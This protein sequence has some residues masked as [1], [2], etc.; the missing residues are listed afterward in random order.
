MNGLLNKDYFVD[1]TNDIYN[2]NSSGYTQRRINK[3]NNYIP[4]EIRNKVITSNKIESNKNLIYK[5]IFPKNE[6]IIRKNN[7]INNN[8]IKSNYYNNINENTNIN[9]N[10]KNPNVIQQRK[11][12]KLINIVD[13]EKENNSL[14][15]DFYNNNDYSSNINYLNNYINKS[16]KYPL[17][18]SNNKK[19]TKYKINTLNTA[20]TENGRNINIDILSDLKGGKYLKTQKSEDNLNIILD[21]NDFMKSI[22]EINDLNILDEI[23]KK[24]GQYF[25]TAERINNMN[26]GKPYISSN[27][28]YEKE[29]NVIKRMPLTSKVNNN[30]N[31]RENKFENYKK[32]NNK[33]DYFINKISKK[34]SNNQEKFN[35]LKN[36]TNENRIFNNKTY[37]NRLIINDDSFY[38]NTENL[39]QQNNPILATITH[40][41]KEESKS[42][43]KNYSLEEIV[44]QNKEY[45]NNINYHSISKYG[46]KSINKK[47]IKN[48]ENINNLNPKEIIKRLNNIIK[49]K[50]NKINSYINIIRQYKEKINAYIQ[51]NIKLNEEKKKNLI[52][53]N[54]YK[55]EINALKDKLDKMNKI[56]FINQKYNSDNKI[57]ELERHLEKYKKENKELKVL[58]MKNKNNQT[59]INEEID[60]KENLINKFNTSS[61]LYENHNHRKKSYSVSKN[62]NNMSIFSLK[63]FLEDE[64]EIN[65]DLKKENHEL[66]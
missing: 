18:S 63:T 46:N 37:N 24:N 39:L 34:N 44:K 42:L 23:D 8:A 7:N 1:Y 65:H 3:I 66:N 49:E 57:K 32:E 56:D 21:K 15:N 38:N 27:E 26:I 35:K 55:S 53:L 12:S 54:K 2:D 48:S 13:N 6:R 45:K 14:L 60:P 22:K 9:Y 10:N 52:L 25:S 59:S 50:N 30:K 16:I 62:R 19:R 64:I 33:N 36:K 28:K 17:N 11:N 29:V 20:D 41:N 4:T 31:I 5:S 47:N 43:P 40:K 58:L 61:F 51:N